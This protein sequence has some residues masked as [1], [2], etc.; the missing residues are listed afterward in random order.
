MRAR[1]RIEAGLVGAVV[2]TAI[3]IELAFPGFWNASIVNAFVGTVNLIGRSGGSALPGGVTDSH[4]PVARVTDAHVPVSRKTAEAP[5]VSDE[6]PGHL[7]RVKENQ[8]WMDGGVFVDAKQL[9][10]GAIIKSAEMD[11][12]GNYVILVY[13]VDGRSFVMFQNRFV[14]SPRLDLGEAEVQSVSVTLDER[15]GKPPWEMIAVKYHDGSTKEFVASNLPE[16][17]GGLEAKIGPEMSG[18]RFAVVE[19]HGL[20]KPGRLV[21]GQLS[22]GQLQQRADEAAVRVREKAFN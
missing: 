1:K 7:L 22:F 12:R 16:G 14:A 11:P 9:G 3:G 21:T 10:K 2:G 8:L 13:Q 4:V 20:M 15:S 19:G 18:I 6:S 17:T 5:G